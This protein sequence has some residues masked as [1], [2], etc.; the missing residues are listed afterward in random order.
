MNRNWHSIIGPNGQCECG[1][2][3]EGNVVTC[4]TIWREES[5]PL[6]SAVSTFM[7]RL[8]REHIRAA[9]D[10]AFETALNESK[11]HGKISRGTVAD[12]IWKELRRVPTAKTLTT[13]L[14]Q[15]VPPTLAAAHTAAKWQFL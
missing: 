11:Y 1:V 10:R 12:E 4:G 14:A 5:A 13:V 15:R 8:S 3:A 9:V 6:E 2:D 7:A